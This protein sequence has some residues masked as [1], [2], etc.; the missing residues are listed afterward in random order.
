VVNVGNYK[1]RL[2]LCLLYVVANQRAAIRR[3]QIMP[4]SLYIL[5]E[6]MT[7]G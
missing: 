6:E 7:T 4:N 2:L 1:R 5:D 3:A